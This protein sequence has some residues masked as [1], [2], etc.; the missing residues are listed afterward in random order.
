MKGLFM[1]VALA[2]FAFSYSNAEDTI[3]VTDAWVREVPPAS[4][5]TAAYMKIGN[6]GGEDDKL[7]GASS[8]AAETVEIHLSSVDDKGVAK[9]EK[10]DGVKVPADGA[11]ELKPGS[12][13]IML[14]GLKEPL[15]DKENVEIVL[16]FE[17]AGKITV[18]APV[19][20]MDKQSQGDH[21]HH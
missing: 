12:Y 13:H 21:S 5:I 8:T 19:K 3:T 4:T 14:I 20:G 10:V 15:T 18:N 6:N 1:A 7:T 16:D 17:N 2:L 11:A 9:M